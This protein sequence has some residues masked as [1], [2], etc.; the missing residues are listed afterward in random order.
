MLKVIKQ[1]FT[2][3]PSLTAAELSIHAQIPVALLQ[4]MLDR[5]VEKGYVAETL[6]QP[7]SGCDLSCLQCDRPKRYRLC[8]DVW[9]ENS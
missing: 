7:C 3:H 6:F 8:F 4:P 5:L 1:C 2:H 9:P